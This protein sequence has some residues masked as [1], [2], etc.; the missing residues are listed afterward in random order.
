MI[1]Y[2]ILLRLFHEQPLAKHLTLGV[3]RGNY[4]VVGVMPRGMHF[5]GQQR[6]A[7]ARQAGWRQ[8]R[9]ADRPDGGRENESRRHTDM[10]QRETTWCSQD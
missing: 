10:L 4:E 3:G 2:E 1:S 9:E 8:P 7:A 5:P 6:V